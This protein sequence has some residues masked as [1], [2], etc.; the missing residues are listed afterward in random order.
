[1]E[2]I[3]FKMFLKPGMAEEYRRRHDR[4]WPELL[5]LLRE[6]GIS[7]YSIFLDEETHVLFAVLRRTPHHRMDSLPQAEVMQRWWRDM[8][9]LMDTQADG[10]PRQQPLRPMFHMA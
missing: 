5:G 8:A 3:A 10:T 4:I 6:A 2:Q 1:M 7:D 9:D